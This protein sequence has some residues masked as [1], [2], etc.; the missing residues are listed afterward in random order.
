[1]DR[2]QVFERLNGVAE[3]KGDVFAALRDLPIDVVA[4]VMLEIPEDYKHARAAFPEMAADEVQDA[5][6]G[7]HGH[8][9]LF[10]S[11]AFVRAVEAAFLKHTGRSL[12]RAR[13]LD[14]GCGWGRLLRLMYKFTDPSTLYGCDP[15]TKSIEL[16][17]ESRVV[18]NLAVC[19]YLPK[20]VP[21]HDTEF[22][23]IYAF[24]VFTHLSEDT[25]RTVLSAFRKCISA[26]GLLVI[27]VRPDSYWYVHNNKTAVVDLLLMH[28][29]HR[30]DKFAFTPHHGK[31]E[32]NVTDA[33]GLNT[34]GDASFSFDYIRTHW[35]EWKLVGYDVSLLD[36]YQTIVFLKP[37]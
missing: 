9:L 16:C 12:D 32:A 28:E 13:I 2:P 33:D 11:A 8:T 21:F 5:W 29:L 10:Q 3:Q 6:T 19:D 30:Q 4:D 31:S 20:E 24:S 37:Q 18:A 22:D 17:R 35:L 14:Y 25:A 36:P 23:L 26:D 27:T 34:Y 1:M 15:W 7:N